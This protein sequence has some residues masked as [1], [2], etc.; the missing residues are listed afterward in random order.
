MLSALDLRKK[1]SFISAILIVT[2]TPNA[3]DLIINPTI[4]S[5][6]AQQPRVSFHFR[7]AV[8]GGQYQHYHR[9]R[10]NDQNGAERETVDAAPPDAPSDEH[11]GLP[12][13]VWRHI[14]LSFRPPANA[15]LR[16]HG[17]AVDRLPAPFTLK[18]PHCPSSFPLHA[19]RCCF[20]E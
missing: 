14:P 13:G 11:K 19:G 10:P 7:L 4:A 3:I 1:N 5:D 20:D 8:V 15:A 9:R 2:A 12:V 6:A 18:L 16:A 17:M